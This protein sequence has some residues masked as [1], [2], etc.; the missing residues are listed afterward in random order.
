MIG[1]EHY[2]LLQDGIIVFEF[3][4][5]LNNKTQ[6]VITQLKKIVFIK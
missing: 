1:C 3:F 5:L 2:I 4:I 6:Y